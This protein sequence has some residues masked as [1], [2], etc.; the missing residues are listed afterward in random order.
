MSCGRKRDRRNVRPTQ[1]WHWSGRLCQT[2]AASELSSTTAELDLLAPSSSEFSIWL[3]PPILRSSLRKATLGGQ[4]WKVEQIFMHGRGRPRACGGPNRVHRSALRSPLRSALRSQ[5]RTPL[6][7]A[8]ET[9]NRP[10]K[11]QM[12]RPKLASYM[13]HP[14]LTGRPIV[15]ISRKI[16]QFGKLRLPRLQLC[17]PLRNQDLTS[18]G[19]GIS[20]V[21]KQR[22]DPKRRLHIAPPEQAL[23]RAALVRLQLLELALPESQ[24]IRRHLAQTGNLPNAK[25]ELVRN[26]RQSFRRWRR[27]LRWSA[28]NCLMARH[29]GKFRALSR[30]HLP[31]GCRQYRFAL[32][33]RPDIFRRSIAYPT[34][35]PRSG[36]NLG[37]VS[38]VV[39]S[40]TTRE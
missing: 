25:V 15:R 8:S 7:S 16:S 20:L 36:G 38:R 32:R 31:P 30:A 27:W 14:I 35:S 24:N 18:S 22:L 19:N 29:G 17:P 21:V 3:I 1:N 39:C 40:A 12:D 23:P 11:H 10:R 26:R 6:R 34:S 5:L 37:C 4:G 9:P 28:A 2:F 33:Q 13:F